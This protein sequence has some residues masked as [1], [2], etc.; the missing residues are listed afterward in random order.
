MR[1]SAFRGTP[2]EKTLDM[3]P[4]VRRGED[5][6][7]FPYQ[8]KADVMINSSLVYELAV[9]K[10][11]IYGPHRQLRLIIPKTGADQSGWRNRHW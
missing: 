11:Y 3:W 5:R 1:D 2:V 10:K 6:Y 7:I 4:S 8:E 9:M